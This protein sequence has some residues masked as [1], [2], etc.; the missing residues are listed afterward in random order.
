M[1]NN[2]TVSLSC[3]FLLF[4]IAYFYLKLPEEE[5]KSVI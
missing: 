1:H 5:Q 4:L 2:E 3:F